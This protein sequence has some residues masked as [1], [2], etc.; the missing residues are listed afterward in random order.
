MDKSTYIDVDLGLKRESI[1]KTSA[2]TIV[3]LLVVIVVI[4]ILATISL[5]SY[6]N[7]Q[8]R[9]SQSRIGIE[10]SQVSKKLESYKLLNDTNEKYPIDISSLNFSPSGGL[11]Y[12]YNASNNG[13]GY[14]LEIDDGINTRS[15]T[16]IDISI[17]AVGCDQN[18]L[19][20]WWTMNNESIDKSGLGNNA[21]IVGATSS[22]GQNG[23]A[24]SAYFFNGSISDYGLVNVFDYDVMRSNAMISSWTLSTWAKWGGSFLPEAV[25][26]GRS[27]CHG[28]IYTYANKYAYAIKGVGCWTGAQT[29]L[30]SA[31]DAN[32]H[33]LTATYDNGLMNFYDNAVSMGSATL[34]D[35]R[36][37]STTL[38]I[39]STGTPS[40]SYAWNGSL[41]DVRVYKRALSQTEVQSLYSKGAQ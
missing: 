1:N 28:G 25:L 41:D 39:G 5:V 4:G 20:G 17:K 37:Y 6:S 35:M 19:I 31:L 30:G 18:G 7:I 8:S 22:V 29:I 9:A 12:S 24:G 26:I 32:W 27:G 2:F 38:G 14:C 11:T 16:N 13:S 21:T 33:L 3:E 15:I 10:L 34:V 36:T 40:A 23:Q